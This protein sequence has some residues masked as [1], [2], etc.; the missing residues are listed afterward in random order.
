MEKEEIYTGF[1]WRNLRTRDY[2]EDLGRDSKIIL[3]CILKKE[4]GLGL[5]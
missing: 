4:C 5:D 2:L 1:W 3:K